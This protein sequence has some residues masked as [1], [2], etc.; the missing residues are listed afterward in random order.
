MPEL[1]LPVATIPH[2][3]SDG[4]R[5]L[6]QHYRIIT[7]A[8]ALEHE[9]LSLDDGKLHVLYYASDFGGCGYYR[10]YTPAEVL[11][12]SQR[13]AAYATPILT[14]ELAHWA[15]I[16]VWQRTAG[17][18]SIRAAKALRGSA[19]FVFDLDD[20]LFS[21]PHWNPAS[22]GMN[23]GEYQRNL[24]EI[25]RT[26]QY[27]TTTND[28]LGRKLRDRHN[29]PYEVIPNCIIASRF[30][31]QSHDGSTLRIGWAGS[32]TH[33]RDLEIA[34]PAIARLQ[35]EY[36]HVRFVVLGWSGSTD[37]GNIF[38]AAGV[39]VEHHPFV[40]AHEYPQALASLQLDIGIAPLERVPFNESKSEIK[41]EEYSALGIPTV[42]SPIGPY[43]TIEH[44]VTGLLASHAG[45]YYRKLRRLVEDHWLR[46]VLGDRA[47]V[48]VL[49]SYGAF[50]TRLLLER[51]FLSLPISLP[52]FS[53]AHPEE[54]PATLPPLH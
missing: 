36:S 41:W 14:G 29:V 22:V 27:I 16:I 19:T 46:R 1:H 40:P 9:G 44:G 13:I 48:T 52:Q 28:V 18:G 53:H 6:E 39:T 42:A 34:L 12:D 26:S 7:G 30:I 38:D 31:P 5:T 4:Y 35:R 37:A 33:L 15:H 47:Q 21:I 11:R 32:S 8:D 51:F 45:D 50:S 2:P 10:A 3:Y 24:L 49:A 25:L 54:H 43:R 23:R 17:D 20:D